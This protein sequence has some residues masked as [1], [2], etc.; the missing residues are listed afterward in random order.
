MEGFPVVS[1]INVDS[2]LCVVSVARLDGTETTDNDQSTPLAETTESPATFAQETTNSAASTFVEETTTSSSTSSSLPSET[3]YFDQST[4]V[5]AIT[6][7]PS[8]SSNLA[9]ESKLDLMMLKGFL[10]LLSLVLIDQ[11]MLFQKEELMM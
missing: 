5:T 4:R 10:L 2:S 6:G 9:L 7:S 8:T 1:A 11:S 3:T